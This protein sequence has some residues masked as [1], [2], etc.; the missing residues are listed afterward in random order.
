M[1]SLQHSTTVVNPSENIRIA[2]L[3]H[4]YGHQWILNRNG[5]F[6]NLVINFEKMLIFDIMR[7]HCNV[8]GDGDVCL[9][10]NLRNEKDAENEKR[11]A[12]IA[13]LRRL[14]ASTKPFVTVKRKNPKAQ[15]IPRQQLHTHARQTLQ[16]FHGHMR[17]RHNGR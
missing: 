14:T 13:Q 11:K 17:T 15:I 7:P 12:N 3:A 8:D 2:P 16:K 6:L 5:A 4:N 10:F 9:I 1:P